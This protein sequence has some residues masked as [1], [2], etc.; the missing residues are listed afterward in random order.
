MVGERLIYVPMIVPT[1]FCPKCGNATLGENRWGP[2][3]VIECINRECELHGVKFRVR[4]P[5]IGLE[6]IV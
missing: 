2:P 3:Q 1:I 6:E 5:V 4:A